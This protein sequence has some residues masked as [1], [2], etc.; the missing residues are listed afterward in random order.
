MSHL[1]IWYMGQIP[2]EVCDAA[3]REFETITPQQA[4]MGTNGEH[5]DKTQRDTVLRFAS[6][7][8]WFGGIL[9]QHGLAANTAT[10]WDYNITGHENVQYGS[11]GPGGHYNWHC[12][13]FPLAGLA[14]ERKVSVICLLSDPAEYGGGELQIQLYQDY[15]VP[16]Q[17]GQM[18]A[19][20]SQLQ[21]RV[22]PVTTGTR[23]S[24]VIWMTGPR[25]R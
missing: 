3:I 21:H 12:D 6:P 14:E 2:L 19:F 17:K 13:T 20:P 10:G 1:P 7:N 11:Y 25:M 16:M 8:H 5:A 15:G 24:A 18:I 4:A 9:Y 23:S 22:L